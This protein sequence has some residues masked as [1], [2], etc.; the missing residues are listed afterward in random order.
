MNFFLLNKCVKGQI[1]SGRSSRFIE[2]GFLPIS[3]CSLSWLSIFYA[4]LVLNSIS[5]YFVLHNLEHLVNYILSSFQFTSGL[6]LTNQ[7]CPRNI[8]VLFKSVTTTLMYSLCLLILTLSSTILVTS[9][10]LV[11]F[12][13]NTSKKKSTSFV[14]ILLSLTI[15]LEETVQQ[16]CVYNITRHEKKV[17]KQQENSV[18]YI[19]YWLI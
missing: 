9:L 12:T 6:Y 4:H 17:R 19:R 1:Y 14:C 2:S 7:L 3:C 11:L 15:V 18:Y 13:L 10:F 8:S 16:T 5:W